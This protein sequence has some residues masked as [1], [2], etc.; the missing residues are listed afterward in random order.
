M[1]CCARRA[2]RG[3]RRA[4]VSFGPLLMAYAYPAKDDNTI[5]GSAAEPVLDP[6]SIAGAQVVRKAMPAVWDWPLDAP[7]KL[8]AKDAAGKPLTLVP[9]GCTKLRVSMFPVD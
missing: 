6:A 7:V 2:C 9:Y 1:N 4:V 8:V 3:K 5:I